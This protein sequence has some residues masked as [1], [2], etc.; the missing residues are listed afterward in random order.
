[1]DGTGSE[2]SRQ[3]TRVQHHCLPVRSYKVPERKGGDWLRHSEAWKAIL[4]ADETV[5]WYNFSVTVQLLNASLMISHP[6]ARTVPLQLGLPGLEDLFHPSVELRNNPETK[7]YLAKEPGT[8]HNE[9]I[10]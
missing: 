6:Q 1:M 3:A 4:K 8:A 10:I 7:P 5:R 2:N 9:I